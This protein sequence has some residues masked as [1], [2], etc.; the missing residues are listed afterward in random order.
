[1]VVDKILNC[2]FNDKAVFKYSKQKQVDYINKLGEPKD[3]IERSYFQYKCQIHHLNIFQRLFLNI[4]SRIALILLFLRPKRTTDFKENV[5]NL[6][7]FVHDE[8]NV[9]QKYRSTSHLKIEQINGSSW[10]S[11]ANTLYLEIKKRYRHH[12]YFLL[13]L[14]KKIGFYQY[15]IDSYKPNNIITSNEYSFTSSVLS[16]LCRRENVRHVD[17][18]HGEKLFYFGDAFFYFDEISVWDEYYLNLFSELKAAYGSETVYFPIERFFIKSDDEPTVD[19]TYYLQMQTKKEMRKISLFLSKLQPARVA[20][21]PHPRYTDISKCKKIFK[22]FEVEDTTN[23]SIEQSL[24]RTKAVISVF[25]TVLLQA[26]CSSIAYYVD[27]ISDAGKFNKL[28]DLNYRLINNNELTR[29]FNH[30]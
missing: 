17:V 11:T 29:L 25:S 3:E 16:L 30:K 26:K 8:R 2:F 4:I 7:V 18:M 22:N 21:R 15:L 28:R 14:R 27:D 19:Y 1:M 9:P 6:F 12:A 24:A 10:S 23:I 5:E 20:V 13:K